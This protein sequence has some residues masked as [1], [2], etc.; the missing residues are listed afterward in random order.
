MKPIIA[1]LI[2][3]IMF[4]PSCI[5]RTTNEPSLP[6]EMTER[7]YSFI[8][9][10][11]VKSPANLDISTSGGNI[12]VT[13][14]DSNTIEVAFVVSRRGR[15]YKMS[16]D[17]LKEI[18]SVVI[19]NNDS[20]LSIKIKDMSYRNMSVGFI[21]KTPY[22]TTA[23]L[24]TS[25][26]NIEVKDIIGNQKFNTSGGNLDFSR[27][28]GKVEASTSGGN[29][30]INHSIAEFHATTSGGNISLDD[31]KGKVDVY[32][33]GGNIEAIS[34]EPEL[35]AH[36]SG[37]NIH[38]SDIKG[39][40]DVG[41]SGGSINLNQLSGSATANT[42]GGSISASMI[43]LT[44]NLDLQTS[45]GNIDARIPSKL[46]L[47][48]DISGDHIDTE[49]QNFSG[50]SNKEKIRGQINGGGIPVKIYT[51]GGSV[52]LSFE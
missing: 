18:A 6:Y 5:I 34:L 9:E 26:G 49:L 33:S 50:T 30:R 44:G 12:T 16:L 21:I 46:G 2:A 15:V 29:I 10:Y 20:G 41:T 36:T 23:T 48:L 22:E 47:D 38:I 4:L 17:E 28:S 35:R 45:G 51:S 32:T 42:S 40:T 11:Q 43:E 31:I 37:G 14:S 52:N 8:Q 1:L 24:N 19:S 27:L 7:D 13:G 25:G 39:L 3:G